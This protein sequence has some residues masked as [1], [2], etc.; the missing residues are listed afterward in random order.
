MK[1]TPEVATMRIEREL[2]ALE[3]SLTE[4]MERVAMLTATLVRARSDTNAGVATGHEVLLRLVSV[5]NSLLKANSDTARVHNG[6]LEIGRELG[7]V[8]EPCYYG[9][10]VRGSLQAA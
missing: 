2:A 6:L 9:N 4:G 3:E 1:M 5:Q 10:L 8:E 7:R